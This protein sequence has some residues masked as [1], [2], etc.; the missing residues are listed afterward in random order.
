MVQ[1]VAV[2]GANGAIGSAIVARL[3]ALYPQAQIVGFARQAPALNSVSVTYVQMDYADEDL[4]R[5]AVEQLPPG[6]CLDL[7]FVA[8]GLLHAGDILPEKS[9]NEL[10]ANKFANVF[11]A[12]VTLPA[13][14]AKHFIPKLA[15]D[16][17]A[18][19]A[20]LSAR[21]GSISDN[22]LG[23]WYAYRASKA[24]LNMVIKTA[25]IEVRRRH[26]QAVIV[27]L[28]PGTV[29]SALSQP[30]SANV[31]PDK[32][33]SPQYAAAKLLTVIEGLSPEDSGKCIAWDG[34][35]IAP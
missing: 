25:A 29:D 23:G 1:R 32:L 31:P 19:F 3:A 8:T 30:F 11:A 16:R 17:R 33:F 24:A 26:K 5:C 18:V 7:V 14:L 6:Q 27:G 28:H 2:I 13:L 9:L 34:Q 10:A 15:T 20:A 35:E 12:N 4:I 22:K 21:V